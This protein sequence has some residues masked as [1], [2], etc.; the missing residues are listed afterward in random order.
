MHE[1]EKNARL[2]ISECRVRLLYNSIP[3][4]QN[5]FRI[6]DYDFHSKRKHCG[7]CYAL[8]RGTFAALSF[9]EIYLEQNPGGKSGCIVNDT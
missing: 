9:R 3:E 6:D 4:T 1:C 8:F 2:A 5:R 7:G